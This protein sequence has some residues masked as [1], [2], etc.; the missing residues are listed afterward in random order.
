VDPTVL[1]GIGERSRAEGITLPPAVID[2]IEYLFVD[3][4]PVRSAGP[5]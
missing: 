1:A 5:G 4:G 2:R 3:T